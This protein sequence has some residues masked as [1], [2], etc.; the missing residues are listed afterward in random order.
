MA[1]GLAQR[2]RH[3]TKVIE[4]ERSLVHV[5]IWFAMAVAATISLADIGLGTTGAMIVG[6]HPLGDD[7][8]AQ[9]ICVE[10]CGGLRCIA[11]HRT[12]QV[13][14]GHMYLGI[15]ERRSPDLL[16]PFFALAVC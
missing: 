7:G 12:S 10:Q 1:G 9:G 11:P 2:L 15:N 13:A 5:S 3:A 6:W 4:M 14:N 16:T 8:L